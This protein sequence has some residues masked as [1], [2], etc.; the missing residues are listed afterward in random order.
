MKTKE[1]EQYEQM[2]T[3]LFGR[4]LRMY[5]WMGRHPECDNLPT[6]Q[7]LALYYKDHPEDD[8]EC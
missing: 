1:S 3:K 6:K 8:V 4:F 2:K 7:A 5:H